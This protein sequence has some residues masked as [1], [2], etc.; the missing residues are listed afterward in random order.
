MKD[1][2]RLI[3]L[4]LLLPLPAFAEVSDKVASIQQLW[5]AAAVAGFVAFLVARYQ[6]ALG[7][8][9]LPVSV[10]LIISGLEPVRDP[11]IGPAVISEQGQAYVWAVYGSATILLALHL[12]GLWLGWR[13]RY[14]TAA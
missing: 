12:V 11:F 2:S 5:I 4:L 6:F 8:I 3:Y 1:F 9:L 7:L 13:R 10:V 14:K